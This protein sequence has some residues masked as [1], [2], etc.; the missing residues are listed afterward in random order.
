VGTSEGYVSL[1]D[2]TLFGARTVEEDSSGRAT[3]YT[4][5]QSDLQQHF[6]ALQI[7]AIGALMNRVR[8]PRCPWIQR[9]DG[10][11]CGSRRASQNA[12][13]RVTA[14]FSSTRVRSDTS[15]ISI[16]HRGVRTRNAYGEGGLTRT[17]LGTQLYNHNSESLFRP[18]GATRWSTTLSSKVNLPHAIIFRA[19][20]GANLVMLPSEFG[21]NEPSYSTVWYGFYRTASRA[22]PTKQPGRKVGPQSSVVPGN[23]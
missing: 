17:R 21:R 10:H 3:R 7:G 5:L 22:I 11:R 16:V 1:N 15:L 20:S 12:P 2:R 23:S 18:S 6:Q 14:V 4:S 19:L 9:R 8:Q 13:I